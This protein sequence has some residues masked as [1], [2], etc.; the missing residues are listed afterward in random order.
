MKTKEF[1]TRAGCA[2]GPLLLA[3]GYPSREA[4]RTAASLGADLM[5]ERIPD[6]LTALDAHIAGLRDLRRDVAKLK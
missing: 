2:A 3:A 6:I 1:R 4:I 5:P